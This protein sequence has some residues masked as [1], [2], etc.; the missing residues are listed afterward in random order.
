VDTKISYS[1]ICA[2]FAGD[3]DICSYCDPD[4]V[5][6]TPDG[7]SLDVYAKLMDWEDVFCGTFKKAKVNGKEVGFVYYFDDILV[8]F[9]VN[10]SHRNKEF[11]ASFFADVTEW[12][13]GDFVTFMWER[14]TR[15]INW[16]EKNGMQREACDMENII[17]LKYKSCP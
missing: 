15:A 16:L 4:A 6:N 9:G 12:I 5:D 1:A 17:K 11:L 3:D 14:N 8:S 2:A 10:K 7:I 13:G